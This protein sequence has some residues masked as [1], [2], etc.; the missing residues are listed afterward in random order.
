VTSVV[1][2]V[3][4]TVAAVAVVMTF[5][6]TSSTGPVA[7]KGATIEIANYAF[8]PAV[9]RVKAGTTIRIT[10]TDP[11][12]HTVTANDHSF[13]TS[14]LASGAHTTIVVLVPGM[15]RYHCN[16]HSFMVGVIQVSARGL[17]TEGGTR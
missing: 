6:L 8:R 3:V 11:T 5:A 1:A 15:Y 4:P 13:A 7:A 9:L 17:P 12:L 10:N 14:T 16:F 2:L